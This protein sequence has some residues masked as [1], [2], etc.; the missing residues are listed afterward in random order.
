MVAVDMGYFA[1][2]DVRPAEYCRQRVRDCDI[3]VA[4]VGFRYGSMVPDAEVSYTELEFIEATATDKLR[5]VFLLD[6]P[7]STGVEAD[8]DRSMVEGFR[9]RLRNAG[10]IVRGFDSPANL[11][12]EVFH[13]LINTVG[14]RR[15]ALPRELPPDVSANSDSVAVGRAGQAHVHIASRPKDARG[16]AADALARNALERWENESAK[17][18]LDS[19]AM[20][21]RWR[22]SRLG[23]D[24]AENQRYWEPGPRFDPLPG[25]PAMEWNAPPEG[26][27]DSLY[28]AYGT[29]A[30]GRV[31]VLGEAGSG[32]SA[33]AVLTVVKALKDCAKLSD[34]VSARVPVP[35]LLTVTGWNP[36]PDR[37]NNLLDWLTARLVADYPFLRGYGHN[38]ARELIRERDRIALFLDGFD[39]MAAEPRREA[40]EQLESARCR[41][42]LFSRTEHFEATTARQ[43]R[44]RA[45]ALELLPLTSAAA[46]EY[47]PRCAPQQ[48][49]PEP[50]KRLISHV[51]NEPDS[52][53][54]R[55]LDSPL[56]LTLIRDGFPEGESPGELP[57]PG[58]F[59]TKDEVVT[60][61]V[62]RLPEVV[63]RHAGA[64]R[65]E[66]DDVRHWL[67]TIASLMGD[68]RSL[69]W[70]RMHHTEDASP[71]A[72][73]AMT[74]AV[75]ML[76]SA[77]TG[78]MMFSHLGKFTTLH[79]GGI[80][81]GTLYMTVI[82]LIFGLAV[83][84]ISELREKN[85][86]KSDRHLFNPAIGLIVGLGVTLEA[87]RLSGYSYSLAAGLL[88]GGATAYSA[89]RSPANSRSRIRYHRWK[90]LYRRLD[91]VTG[92][93][94]ALPIAVA[95]WQ[96][97]G[98]AYGLF[99]SAVTTAAVAL[100][101]GASRPSARTDLPVDPPTSQKQD[102]Q[103]SVIFGLVTGLCLGVPF[104]LRNG[105]GSGSL[106]GFV[107]ALG[108][109]FLIGL[110]CWGAVS[111]VWRSTL[112]L[113]QL[114]HRNRFPLR[115]LR[116]LNEAYDLGILRA[117]GVTYQF[118]HARLQ[119]HLTQRSYMTN[120]AA[121][122]CGRI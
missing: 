40:I 78:A 32:K 60:Y 73:I 61:L 1:A 95:S 14:P 26:G 97:N 67:G 89:A 101:A 71:R 76:V 83:G 69:D 22:W 79:R 41:V 81:Y 99:A 49:M 29:A 117:E 112:F 110:A 106:S 16:Q 53:L 118:R 33:V 116:F 20:P 122:R 66:L 68:K 4:I 77:P 5:L 3:Y 65:Y 12:L 85:E 80:I 8:A 10:L 9:Q 45:V 63:Y 36:K 86:L 102:L 88:A 113:F 121:A 75:G 58:Q 107:I 70:R 56:A 119:D 93:I 82:G 39:E 50:W 98:P 108:H 59:T 46:A 62:A 13:A 55:A 94:A 15:S 28:S 105:L 7:A 18:R 87:G 115:G 84:S 72:R 54:S 17:R 38:A 11:E 52:V 27:I 120:V 24:P 6:E 57:M 74:G 64:A 92:C 104:G 114:H 21:V 111:D 103:R 91:L 35:V 19:M 2:Q 37:E 43:R 42:V 44:F 109:I 23:E 90:Q 34:S 47:L 51:E 48:P 25:V 96:A 100:M 30:S 31:V